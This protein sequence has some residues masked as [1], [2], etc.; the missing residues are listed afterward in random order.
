ME[1]RLKLWADMQDVI[2]PLAQWPDSIKADFWKANVKHWS[3]IMLAAFVFVNGLNPVIFLEWVDKSYMCRDVAA[4]RHLQYLCDSFG[5][6][7]Y[8]YT[9]YAYNVLSKQWQF[10]D[11][12]IK[13][14]K[15]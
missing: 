1:E 13:Q 2:G 7:K 6:G 3:R 8:L 15:R 12:R 11:G 9:V 10:L 5:K 14:F 4:R